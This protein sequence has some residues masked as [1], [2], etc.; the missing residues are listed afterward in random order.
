MSAASLV[1]SIFPLALIAAALSDVRRF[2]I[3]NWT[4]LLL[5][6]GFLTAA[7]A[8]ALTGGLG[9]WAFS[10]HLA[11]GLTCFAVGFGLWAFGLWGG[12]DAK[13]FAAAALWFDPTAAVMMTTY[14]LLIGGGF[15]VLALM[16]L[17]F[18]FA[19][20]QAIPAAGQIDFEKYAKTAPYG[21][22]IAAG[23]LLALPS[24]TLFI[25]LTS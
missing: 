4:S 15:G 20:A 17:K 10:L 2:I 22:A 19:I 18:R 8:A 24:S 23:A 6:G 16:A 12:G 1:L 5:I 11:V 9:L 21:V 7:V 14:I 25:A 3:P 13:L